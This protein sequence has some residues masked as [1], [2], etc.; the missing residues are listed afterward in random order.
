MYMSDLSDYIT[1]RYFPVVPVFRSH[2]QAYCVLTDIPNRIQPDIHGLKPA[3]DIRM[4]RRHD[5]TDAD[6]LCPLRNPAPAVSTHTA[7]W[8]DI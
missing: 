2:A 8:T 1:S 3:S 6:L 7:G 4:E 5:V